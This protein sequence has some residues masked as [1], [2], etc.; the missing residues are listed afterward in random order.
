M[1]NKISIKI[2]FLAMLICLFV[3]SCKENKP[4]GDEFCWSP[5]GNKLAMI[6]V[7]SQELLI[8]DI[9]DDCIENITPIDNYSGE[10]AKIYAP[11]WSTDGQF[12]LYTKS[13]KE[14]LDIFVYSLP[15]KKHTH[16][17]NFQIT[18]QEN[19]KGNA[20]PSWSPTLNEIL[21]VTW[22]NLASHQ[23]FSCLPDGKNKKLLI[24]VIGEE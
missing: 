4:K 21:W 7:E 8:V 6:N 9:E 18:E 15:G 13:N 3:A 22:N 20:F 24:K 17:D 23:I 16:I 1:N 10:K 19:L 5:D 14:S 12:L 11:T 2:L